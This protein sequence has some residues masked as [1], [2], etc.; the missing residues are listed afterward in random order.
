MGF[1]IL[2]LLAA[3]A[4]ASHPPARVQ[5]NTSGIATQDFIQKVNHTV[6][7]SSATF[8]QRYQLNTQYFESGGPILFI[9][10]AEAGMPVINASDFM[11]YAPKLGAL[12]AMLEHRFFGDFHRGSYPPDFDPM[13]ITSGAFN[14]LTMDN[15]LQ[16]G[17]D[18]V[19]WIKKT[20]RGAANSRV[21]YGGCKHDSYS[22]SLGLAIN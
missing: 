11:D 10:S 5:S 1:K 22:R 6:D 2:V 20:V 18:F 17:V 12:V 4:M 14:S 19:N 9:Q 21:I 7:A 15:V 16:D 8:K 3:M 13:N